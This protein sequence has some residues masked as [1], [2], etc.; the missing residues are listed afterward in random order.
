MNK[1]VVMN[2]GL[3]G[4]Y[5][6]IDTWQTVWLEFFSETHIHAVKITR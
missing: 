2:G 5:K 4:M 1:Q 3:A 6:T